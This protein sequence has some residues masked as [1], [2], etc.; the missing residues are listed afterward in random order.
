MPG[1]CPAHSKVIPPSRFVPSS[2]VAYSRALWPS[3]CKRTKNNAKYRS[4]EMRIGI[5]EDAAPSEPLLWLATS[6][7]RSW[8]T[9]RCRRTTTAPSGIFAVWRRRVVT[10]H[11]PSRL[12]CRGVRPAQERDRHWDEEPGSV[13]GWSSDFSSIRLDGIGLDCYPETNAG[14]IP[15]DREFLTCLRSARSTSRIARTAPWF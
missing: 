8:T 10:A 6:C 13:L 4:T 7:L 3:R 2:P 14:P 9:R 12:E 5:G 15:H 1:T 11:A